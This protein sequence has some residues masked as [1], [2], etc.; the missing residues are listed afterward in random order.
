MTTILRALHERAVLVLTALFVVFVVAQAGQTALI[1]ASI[2]ALAIAG[3][4]AV[5]YAALVVG[6]R[7]MTVGSRAHAHREALDVMAAPRHPSTAGRPRTRAPSQP[8]P[9]A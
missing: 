2:A 1:V 8:I 4:V 3:V 5:S 9:A 6:S 7:V